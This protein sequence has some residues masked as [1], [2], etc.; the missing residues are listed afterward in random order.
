MIMSRIEG[1][2]MNKKFKKIS[3]LM[4]IISLIMTSFVLPVS[5]STFSDTNQHWA[6]ESIQ[7]WS[8]YG[9]VNGFDGK[10]RPDDEV[11]RAEFSMMIN[12]I[13]KY[14]E[15]EENT[16]SDLDPSQWY[17]EAMLKLNA[18]GVMNGVNGQALPNQ[19]I[20]RQEAAVMVARAFV[21]DHTSAP[22]SFK[23]EAE[24]A[25]W[26]RSAVTSL[27]VA[28]VINGM[29]DGTFRPNANLTR[30]EAVTIFNNFIG[31]LI[32]APG[33]YSS[34]VQG[35]VVV[36]S[37]DAI[38]EEMTISGDLYI[39][40]GVGE[41]DVT[42]N[43]VEIEGN[44]YVFG[45]G[46][47]SVIFNNVDVRGALVV[48]HYNGNVRIL[49][50]GNT[51][52]AV[53][54]L[55][56]G[57]LIVTRELTGGGFQTIEISA[58][59]A[60]GQN[61]VLDGNFTKVV[62]YSESA[63]ITA[64]GTIQELVAEVDTVVN[65]DVTIEKVT[66]SDS[67][68]T[69]VNDEPVTSG[70]EGV[71]GGGGNA[72]GSSGGNQS[73][74]T[75][76]VREVTINEGDLSL[77]VG[78]TKQLTATV[79]P[80]NAS[81]KRVTW[82]VT[83]GSTDVVTVDDNGWVTAVAEGTK[84]IE[85][86]TNSR[87]RTDQITVTVAKPQFGI[88]LSKFAGEKIES[89]ASID[90]II[91]ENSSALSVLKVSQS[92]HTGQFE[93][94]IV[95]TEVLQELVESGHKYAN[96]VIS[97][98]DI[99]G[100]SISETTDINTTV[101]G[102]TYGNDI[103]F[104]HLLSD[105]FKEG[106]FVFTLD[107]GNPEAI[108]NIELAFSHEDYA[109]TTLSI[110]FIPAGITYIKL[111]EPIIGNAEVNSVLSAIP[112]IIIG[113]PP[114][115]LN[116]ITYQWLSATSKE[117]P[118]TVID[119][120]DST[121][122]TVTEE[123]IGKYI[124]VKVSGDQLSVA[125][126]AISDAFGPIEEPIRADDVFAAIEA[127]YLA[128]NVDDKN[129]ISNLNMVNSLPEYPNI[130]IIWTSSD[131][132]VV[133]PTGRVERSSESDK[134]VTLTAEIFGYN[135][136]GA[137]KKDYHI[138]VPV[139]RENTGEVE[140]FIDPYFSTNYPQSY[141]K[142]GEIWVKFKLDQPAEVFMVVNAYYGNESST[143]DAVLQG[144]AGDENNLYYVPSWPYFNVEDADKIY[145]FNTGAYFSS[146]GP[147][148]IEFVIQDQAQSYQSSQVTTIEFE[149]EAIEV[150]GNPTFDLSPTLINQA[151]NKIYLYSFNE[152]DQSS[153]PSIDDFE[154]N[155]GS[156]DRVSI[157]HSG[158]QYFASYV[159]LEVSGI[160][161]ADL[162][163]LEIYYS[164]NTIQEKVGNKLKAQQRIY[165]YIQLSRHE[166]LGSILSQD[167][168]SMF[169][170]IGTSWDAYSDVIDAAKLFTVEVDGRTSI[171]PISAEYRSIGLETVRYRL[172]FAEEIPLGNLSLKANMSGIKNMAMDEYPKELVSTN[173][174][175]LSDA[176]IPTAIYSNYGYDSVLEIDFSDH[177]IFGSGGFYAGLVLEIDG[178]EY[179]LRG[180]GAGYSN[181]RIYINL[182]EWYNTTHI[183]EIID[184][185]TNIRIKYEPVIV[186][187]Y[188]TFGDVF[189]VPAIF[190]YIPVTKR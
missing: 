40:Q 176:G 157:G 151:L 98:K 5:A 76:Q 120:A 145:E 36:N 177:Y 175:E 115:D 28:K 169:V 95:A 12:N 38:L 35:N 109:D 131:Y 186:D 6:A 89:E 63:N 20:S 93:A 2:T 107:V 161:R 153:P 165:N 128:N 106:S 114:A 150:I 37:T 14:I 112:P 134:S 185:G 167:R 178:Q 55:E 146:F 126:T 43:D 16:F 52:V 83:D 82:S 19:N 142:N 179:Q 138:I 130:S 74:S 11:T 189:G 10:F 149:Q 24:I 71:V 23:D 166:I 29:P 59:I 91:L 54:Q 66:S 49:A 172:T 87:G 116:V 41:G 27:A 183:K 101:T 22:I 129:V 119:G 31:S 102:D 8:E 70:S 32:S 152:L 3:A 68:S 48:N 79:L 80:N 100:H 15:I 140:D 123:D 187:Q 57:A 1:G 184:A 168:K 39:A 170:E 56:S 42:L 147:T 73:S 84:T 65:G 7:T 139:A 136:L 97:L 124:R 99:H 30:A 164:G 121:S 61:I 17:F 125:G 90:E 96:V 46:E 171:A 182:G 137:N 4:L 155:V 143:V 133:S 135:I 108:Q 60:A 33:T 156:I 122:Y 103:N 92:V 77:V 160:D 162:N 111:I 163:N 104:G 81:N 34:D 154:L 51:S 62:N 44:V 174:I 21:A 75:V 72:S 144:R 88:H 117:G 188:Y 86:V 159:L 173:I 113:A 118:Y 110:Q 181:N 50:T 53:T 67:A 141:V 190:D 85:V 13:M 25:S 58:E 78:E 158:A 127:V 47:N 26:A 105:G 64:N 132:E 180:F 94:S 69:T 9:V 148:K 18:A 45:G